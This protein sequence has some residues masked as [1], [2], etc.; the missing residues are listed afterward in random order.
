MHREESASQVDLRPAASARPGPAVDLVL[1]P[2]HL[3]GGGQAAAG[4]QPGETSGK[5]NTDGCGL[6]RG[7]GRVGGGGNGVLMSLSIPVSLCLF[8][9][10]CVCFW[11]PCKGSVEG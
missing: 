9:L 1:L 3:R 4:Q 5:R 7:G 10:V 2:L 11:G 6:D 8:F